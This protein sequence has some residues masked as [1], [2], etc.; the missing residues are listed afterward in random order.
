MPARNCIG[1][2][3]DEMLIVWYTLRDENAEGENYGVEQTSK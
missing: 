1:V 3:H 2:F